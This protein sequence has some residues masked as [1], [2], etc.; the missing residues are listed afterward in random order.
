MGERMSEPEDQ[1]DESE[2]LDDY[3][4]RLE[5]ERDALRRE[6]QEYRDQVSSGGYITSLQVEIGQWKSRAKK[7]AEIF[8]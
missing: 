5:A 2:G 6:Y 7:L 8:H 1:I 3:A 4:R